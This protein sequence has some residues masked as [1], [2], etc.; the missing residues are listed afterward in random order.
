MKKDEANQDGQANEVREPT[1]AYSQTITSNSKRTHQ[2]P[3][4]RHDNSFTSEYDLYVKKVLDK[5][6]KNYLDHPDRC[7][8]HDQF[9]EFVNKNLMSHGQKI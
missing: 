7:M 4:R 5:S 2:Q 1:V 9:T 8:T 3:N 6:I